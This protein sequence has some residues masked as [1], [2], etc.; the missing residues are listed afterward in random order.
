[1][2]TGFDGV[3]FQVQNFL[4]T[5]QTWQ[6]R[7]GQGGPA[8]L[9]HSVAEVLDMFGYKAD[10]APKQQSGYRELKVKKQILFFE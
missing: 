3:R 1:M 8:V 4:C 7:A 5:L 9:S 6:L 2:C 10:K